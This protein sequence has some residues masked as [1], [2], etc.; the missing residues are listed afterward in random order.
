M[1]TNRYLPLVVLLGIVLLGG[2]PEPPMPDP[3][4][5]GPGTVGSL[6]LSTVEVG[7]ALRVGS[8]NKFGLG[9]NEGQPSGLAAIGNTLYM[10]GWGEDTY[11]R[12]ANGR[13][14]RIR[15]AA[16]P[17]LYTVDASTGVATR[18]GSAD[19]FGV[20]EIAP[21]GLAVIGDTLYMAGNYNETVYTLN[22]S[23]GVATPVGSRLLETGGLGPNGLAAVGNTLYMVS[24]ETDALYTVDTTTGIAARRGSAIQ[25][26]TGNAPP[27]TAI[28]PFGLVA[29]GNVLYMVDIWFQRIFTVDTGTGIATRVGNAPRFGL[30]GVNE[31]IP[32]GL[33]V[34]GDILYMVGQKH[35]ALYI[36]RYR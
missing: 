22:T 4:T 36:V 31:G 1:N 27:S 29:I 23:T 26:G 19:K 8:V 32:S 5:P 12:D 17:A 18:V 11:D 20:N 25:F 16:I 34:I 6:D 13:F 33:A 24:T 2:C 28:E 9:A 3:P 21:S 35:D 7:E 10:V 14:I 15:T 30:N